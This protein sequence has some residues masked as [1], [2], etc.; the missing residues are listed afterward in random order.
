M[1][2]SHY[3][4]NNTHEA[5]LMGRRELTLLITYKDTSLIWNTAKIYENPTA[6]IYNIFKKKEKKPIFLC[7]APATL[8]K[9]DNL[10]YA[11]IK[12]WPQ[13]KS[14]ATS[15]EIRIEN[16]TTSPSRKRMV[17][18]VVANDSSWVTMMKVWPRSRRRSKKSRCSS[19]LFCVSRL[20]EGSS[21]SITCGGSHGRGLRRRAASRLLKAQI[22]SNVSIPIVLQ[23]FKSYG[24]HFIIAFLLTYSIY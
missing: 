11:F 22:N 6:N 14:E 18:S 4:P 20:P 23:A 8:W 12:K 19:S 15:M 10:E 24:W 17:R 21:A 2:V 5:C 7:F 1:S 13:R 16:Q 9:E 3:P